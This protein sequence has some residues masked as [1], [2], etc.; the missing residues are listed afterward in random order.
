MDAS[1]VTQR[2]VLPRDC[3]DHVLTFCDASTTSNAYLVCRS[4][5]HAVDRY[6]CVAD[7]IY[8]LPDTSTQWF[9]SSLLQ[10]FEKKPLYQQASVTYLLMTEDHTVSMWPKYLSLCL[11]LREVIVNV[12]FNSQNRNRRGYRRQVE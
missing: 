10:M 9:P 7:K 11:A 8:D 3:I 1:P 6:V 5:Y 12:I 2:S 4:W